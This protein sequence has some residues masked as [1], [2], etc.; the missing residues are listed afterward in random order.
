MC[1]IICPEGKIQVCCE[2]CN[3]TYQFQEQVILQL[4][5]HLGMWCLKALRAKMQRREWCSRDLS[6][7]VHV[8]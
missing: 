5:K 7:H 8:M 3:Q 1:D 4:L 2:I 6:E